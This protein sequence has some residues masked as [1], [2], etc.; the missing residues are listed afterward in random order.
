M[1]FSCSESWGDTP[2]EYTDPWLDSDGTV[3]YSRSTSEAMDSTGRSSVGTVSKHILNRT[4][5]K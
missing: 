1:F 3:V 4:V 2:Y 5:P